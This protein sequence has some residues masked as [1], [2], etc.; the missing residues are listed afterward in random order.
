MLLLIEPDPIFTGKRGN[1]TDNGLY[2]A[3]E[4]VDSRDDEH[5]VEPADHGDASVGPSAA[6]GKR[7]LA[8]PMM[9]PVRNR[10]MGGRASAR[11]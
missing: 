9:S 7:S 8:G 3:W 2:V 6:A 1:L 10:I 4:D 5:I 11:W